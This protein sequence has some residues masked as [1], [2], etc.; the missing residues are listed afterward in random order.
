MALIVNYHFAMSSVHWSSGSRDITYLICHVASKENL[1]EGSFDVVDRSYSLYITTM[2]SL[3]AIAIVVLVIS[4]L[5][6]YVISQ[7][8]VT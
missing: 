1:I 4:F 5:I 6:C 3:L 8:C 7:D 2:Q